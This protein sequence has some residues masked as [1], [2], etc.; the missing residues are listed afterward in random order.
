ML[1]ETLIEWDH[2]MFRLINHAQLG[3]VGD[4]LVRASPWLGAGLV[5]VPFM[6]ALLVVPR[7]RVQLRPMAVLI[8]LTFMLSGVVVLI[9]KPSIARP[10]PPDIAAQLAVDDN[11]GVIVRSANYQHRSFPS[12]H[13]QSAFSVGAGVALVARRRIWRIGA[14]GIAVMVGWSRIY[15]GVHFPLD[16]L[17]GACL[18]LG[19]AWGLYR[20]GVHERIWRV[21]DTG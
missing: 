14:L 20:R 5:L 10:R 7:R 4:G 3:P 1:F 21:R 13:T 16:V 2:D 17:A 6:L 9:L 8:A 15:L 19:V 12:G 18:A 11:P